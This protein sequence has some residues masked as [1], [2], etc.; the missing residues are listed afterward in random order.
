ME[1]LSFKQHPYQCEA[2]MCVSRVRSWGIRTTVVVVVILTTTGDEVEHI[3]KKDS[4]FE[5]KMLLSLLVP[6]FWLLTESLKLV[7]LFHLWKLLWF[8]GAEEF[9]SN[10]GR[11]CNELM[12]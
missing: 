4:K 3:M 11:K 12:V 2:E 8:N 7:T 10:V 5:E 6:I 9:M 1:I